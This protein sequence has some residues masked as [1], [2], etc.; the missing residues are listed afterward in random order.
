M[1]SEPD[2]QLSHESTE[3]AKRRPTRRR[4]VFM[5]AMAAIAVAIVAGAAWFA[6]RDSSDRPNLLTNGDFETGDLAGWTVEASGNYG[7]TWGGW[8][9]YQDGLTPPTDNDRTYAFNVFEVSD[10]PQ[11]LYAAVSDGNGLGTRV[12]YRNIQIDGPSLLRATVFYM[13]EFSPGYGF[14]DTRIIAPDNFTLAAPNQQYRIDLI[15]PEAP[16]LS[17]D[18]GDILATLFHTQEGDPVQLEPTAVSLDLSPWEGQTVR[19]RCVEI[20]NRGRFFAGID[21][22]RVERR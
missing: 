21:D 8:Y 12:L 20:D 5:I 15:D 6:I 17:A 18:S 19:L 2:P 7:N 1:S 10:P 4:G 9:V 16:L 3:V 22:V 14:G 11:G 13:T